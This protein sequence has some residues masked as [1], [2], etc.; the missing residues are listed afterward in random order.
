MAQG[1]EAAR[2][3]EGW[4]S[5]AAYLGRDRST[6]IRWARERGLPVHA[7]PGGRSRSVYAL[8][9][10][11][12]AWISGQEALP[13]DPAPP[14]PP[15]APSPPA[16][17]PLALP[18]PA[19]P[20]RW[21]IVLGALALLGISIAAIDWI[22]PSPDRL[23]AA[24]HA[25]FVAA[26]DDV[27]MRSAPRLHAA[28][29][30]L[31]RL[32]RAHPGNVEVQEALAEA[33]LLTREFGSASD[34]LSIG[35]ARAAA[36]A[37]R[38]I[39]P[40]SAVADR[41]DGVIAYWWDGKP[42][43]AGELFR[44]AIGHAPGD[45]LAHLWYANILADN[46]ED[47]A[48]QREFDAARTL[49]PGAPWLLAD[50][51]W[52]LWSAG[53]T[54]QAQALLTTVA[55]QYPTLASVHDALSVT[56]LAEGDVAGYARHLAARARARGE[57]ELITYSTALQRTIDSDR[58]V[59]NGPAATYAVILSRAVAIT[60]NDDP[61][62]H[63]WPAFVAAVAGDRATLVAILD[64]ARA[65]GEQWGSAGFVRRIRARFAGDHAIDAALTALAQP[66]IDPA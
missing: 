35:R 29:A 54:A 37:A 62:D 50:Y 43:R 12:D 5:I 53:R 21:S 45:P 32:A 66:R 17:D 28:I 18:R 40:R 3:I 24:T 58:R 10:E 27:A 4:K 19:P 11:L 57:P 42:Q 41:V 13:P 8:A 7:L 55:S 26:R 34:T 16:P 15:P 33:W 1:G 31:T 9:H 56:A 30:V 20:Q 46:G 44:R 48:A 52:G 60:Q 61:P 47:A 59:G 49:A 25:R 38:A 51:G 64:N 23:D 63:S 39:D 2:R 6:A 14:D 22:G 36:A 65:R